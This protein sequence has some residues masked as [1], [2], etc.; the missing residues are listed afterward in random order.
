MSPMTIR[1]YDKRTKTEITEAVKSSSFY[2]RKQVLIEG[3]NRGDNQGISH[4][5]LP[6]SST[7]EAA[8]GLHSAL[9]VQQNSLK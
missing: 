3:D 2:N 1:K 4:I 9:E 6:K 7:N 8:K 5:I